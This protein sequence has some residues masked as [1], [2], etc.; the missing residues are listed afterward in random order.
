MY[1]YALLF[2]DLVQDEKERR[3]L[4]RRTKEKK[5]KKNDKMSQS[6]DIYRQNVD[7]F[8]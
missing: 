1:D 3:T 4:K 7:S 5:K 6:D 8:F 2:G